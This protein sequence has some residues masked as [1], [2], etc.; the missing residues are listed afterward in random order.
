MLHKSMPMRIHKTKM[1][2]NPRN[3]VSLVH[4]HIH[5]LNAS[6]QTYQGTRVMYH[7]T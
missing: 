7:S 1:Q 6:T 5:T 2:A 4:Q 3:I